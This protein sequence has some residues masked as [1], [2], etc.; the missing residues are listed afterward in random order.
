[1][2]VLYRYGTKWG[3]NVID[4]WAGRPLL[5]RHSKRERIW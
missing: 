1:M 3:Y 2:K 4:E 5:L